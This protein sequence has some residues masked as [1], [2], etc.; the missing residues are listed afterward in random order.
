MEKY[1]CFTADQLKA[2]KSIGRIYDTTT[3]QNTDGGAR[4]HAIEPFDVLRIVDREAAFYE[5]KKLQDKGTN[6]SVVLRDDGNAYIQFLTKDELF[7]HQ[8]LWSSEE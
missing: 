3:R 8:P 7:L 6:V 1:Y 5:A 2:D 4:C